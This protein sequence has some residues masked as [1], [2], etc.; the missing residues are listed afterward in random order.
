MLEDG[1][2]YGIALVELEGGHLGEDEDEIL[3]DDLQALESRGGDQSHALPRV[4]DDG[5]LRVRPDVLQELA[6]MRKEEE[7]EG[8]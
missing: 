7:E 8:G 4:P 5:T 1:E 2:G 3:G 6:C